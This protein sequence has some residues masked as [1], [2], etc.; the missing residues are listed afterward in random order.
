M[1][2]YLF[3]LQPE[4]IVILTHLVKFDFRIQLRAGILDDL[5]AN[6]RRETMI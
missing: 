3:R 1:L 4:S 6:R 2:V 5:L